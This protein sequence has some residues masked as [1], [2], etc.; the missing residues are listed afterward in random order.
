MIEF[1]L[2]K[3]FV[4]LRVPSQL[5]LKIP[6]LKQAASHGLTGFLLGFCLFP[7]PSFIPPGGE[8]PG[9]VFAR[10]DLGH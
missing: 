9:L 3:L 1:P 6:K 7:S 8:A 4:A 10:Q 5:R 2:R